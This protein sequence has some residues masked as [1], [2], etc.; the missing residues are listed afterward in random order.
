MNLIFEAWHLPTEQR[1]LWLDAPD[2]ETAIKRARNTAKQHG[3]A[4][5][6]FVCRADP[7]VIDA[8]VSARVTRFGEALGPALAA[9]S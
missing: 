7:A 3:L 8:D 4:G 1:A 9:Q 6:L 5:D 2:L